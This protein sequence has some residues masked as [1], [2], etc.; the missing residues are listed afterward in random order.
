[1]TKNTFVRAA[2]SLAA[3]GM[4]FSAA[5]PAFAQASASAT[6]KQMAQ[7]AQL[8]RIIARGDK[9]IDARVADLTT[10][11]S[12]I[13]DMKNLSDSE[14][15]TLTATVQAQSVALTALKAKLDADTD[16]ATALSDEKS[17]TADYRIYALVVPQGHIAAASDRAITIAGLLDSA[18]GKLQARIAAAQAAGKDVTAVSAILADM[19]AKISDLK[20]QAA[21]AGNSVLALVPDKG[22]ATIAASNKA[23]LV[24]ARA[25]IKAATADIQAARKDAKTLLADIKAFHLPAAAAATSTSAMTAAT[26]SAQ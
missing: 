19:N 6:K 9:A 23:A 20:T 16:N 26:S 17:I 1:M 25:D 10:L 21:T 2:V 18:A 12:R 5:V 14:K 3:A 13:G 4:L 7:S 8:S 22:D 24:A 11:A 15:A